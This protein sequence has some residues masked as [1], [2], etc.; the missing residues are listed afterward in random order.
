LF[1]HKTCPFSIFSKVLY[2]VYIISLSPDVSIG[3]TIQ[4]EITT[5]RENQVTEVL[6][7]KFDIH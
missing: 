3:Y 1:F 4:E 6:I 7:T 5:E 2:D